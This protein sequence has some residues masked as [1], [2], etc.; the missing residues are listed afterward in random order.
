MGTITIYIRL[1]SEALN[2]EHSF[3]LSKEFMLQNIDYCKNFDNVINTIRYVLKE[4]SYKNIPVYI[5]YVGKFIFDVTIENLCDEWIG[6]YR[7]NP[8]LLIK[9]IVNKVKINLYVFR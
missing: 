3:N 1:V 2:T 4:N 8:D 9:E 6:L 5:S 7:L